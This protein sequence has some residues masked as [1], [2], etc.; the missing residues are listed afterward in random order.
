MHCRGEFASVVKVIINT[1]PCPFRCFSLFRRK[2]RDTNTRA[3]GA[4]LETDLKKIEQNF[5]AVPI[6]Q[7]TGRWL[8]LNSTYWDFGGSGDRPLEEPESLTQLYGAGRRPCHFIPSL[9]APPGHP[10][11]TFAQTER[12]LLNYFIEGIGPNCSLSPFYNPYLSLV[13]PLALSHAPLRNTLLAIAANQFC[14]L[15]NVRFEKEAYICKQRALAG[16]Q[17]EINEQKPSFGAI[18][19]VLMLCFHDVCSLLLC[20]LLSFFPFFHESG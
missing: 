15:G 5:Q 4:K 6:S 14:R 11:A 10:L 13:T 8:F 3:V 9:Q 16:L 12:Y 17:K 20:S 1:Y 2:R 7:Y 19:T 18:A